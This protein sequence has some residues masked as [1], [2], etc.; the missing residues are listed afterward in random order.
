MKTPSTPGEVDVTVRYSKHLGPRYEAA[1][2]RI[3]YHYNQVPGVSFRVAVNDEY[4]ASIERGISDAMTRRFPDFPSNGS[5]W[6]V[7]V[8]EDP[9]ASSQVAFYR[10]AVAAVEQAYVVAI[11]PPPE[12]A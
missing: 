5:V 7:E 10:A 8:H 11:T 6:V 3:Q 9:V 4:R 2:L 12:V 1:G